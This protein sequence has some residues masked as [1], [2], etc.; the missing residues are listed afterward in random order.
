[1]AYIYR[2]IRLDKNEP[3]YIGVGGLL[4][5][6]GFYRAYKKSNRSKYWRNII[7]KTEYEVEILLNDISINEALSKEKYFIS[8]YGRKNNNTGCLVNLTDGGDGCNNMKHS[9]EIKKQQ[10]ERVS[11]I[12][13]PNYGK[14]TPI[15]VKDKI[16]KKLIGRKNIKH[17]ANMVNNKNS[18]KKVIDT[19][20]GNIFESAK[21][22][23]L[24]LNMNY[25]T[26]KAMLNGYNPNKTT[27]KYLN[28]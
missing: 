2:H 27:L 14:T 6:D 5:N 8:L 11:G 3:F 12:N 21:N 22:A 7:S 4:N 1:M 19:K 16:R 25:G 15:N 24:Y 18:C 28:K 9:E 20:T 17:S 26:L 10:S 23:S 13:H